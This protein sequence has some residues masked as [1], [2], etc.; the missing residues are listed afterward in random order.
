[1]LVPTRSAT[2]ACGVILAL[3]RCPEG[4]TSS[5]AYSGTARNTR[6]GF[7]RFVQE[8]L[9][10]GEGLIASKLIRKCLLNARQ[11]GQGTG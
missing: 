5:G 8:L 10:G 1:M 9:G 7:N 6:E 4:A 11:I 3:L 2:A